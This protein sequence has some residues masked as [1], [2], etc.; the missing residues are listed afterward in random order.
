MSCK[1]ALYLQHLTRR[2]RFSC[3]C[4]PGR[5]QPLQRLSND[6]VRLLFTRAA[7]SNFFLAQHRLSLLF[8]HPLASVSCSIISC[9]SLSFCFAFCHVLHDR[10]ESLSVFWR[11]TGKQNFLYNKRL[12]QNTGPV[13]SFEPHCYRV[14]HNVTDCLASEGLKKLVLFNKHPIDKKYFP[15]IHIL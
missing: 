10:W 12:L 4:G 5:T 15:G 6:L 2:C 13:L 8:H 11:K 7:T 3:P 9:S 14:Q 1:T